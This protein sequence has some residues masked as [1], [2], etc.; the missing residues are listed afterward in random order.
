[1]FFPTQGQRQ[2]TYSRVLSMQER[3]RFK[4]MTSESSDKSSVS[5]EGDGWNLLDA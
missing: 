1:M 2:H 4:I 5:C 3:Q